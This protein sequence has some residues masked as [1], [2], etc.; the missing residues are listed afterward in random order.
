MMITMNLGVVAVIWFGGLQVIGGTLEVGKVMA[1]INYL[2][3]LLFSLMMVAFI[4]MFI[5]R[6]QAS[7][8]R[9]VNVLEARPE[10]F[11]REETVQHEIRGAVTFDRVT[12]ATAARLRP[13]C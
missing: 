9:I 1:F 10:I 12:F 3:M 13:P 8:D 6:A 4:L 2:L 7:A 5:S 11:D